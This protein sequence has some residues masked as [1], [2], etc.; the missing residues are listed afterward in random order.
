VTIIGQCEIKKTNLIFFVLL[1][2]T[3]IFRLRY[4]INSFFIIF[5]YYYDY[6]EFCDI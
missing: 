3:E 2:S 6:I 5:M 4:I 1:Q